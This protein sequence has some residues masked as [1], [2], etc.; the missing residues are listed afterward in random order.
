[1][2]YL[3][4]LINF[5]KENDNWKELLKKTPYNLKTVK[6][7]SWHPNWFMFVYNLF[8]SDLSNYVVRA[9]RGTVLEINGK[10]VKVISYPYSKFDN[11][12]SITCKDIEDSI[13]WSNASFCLKVDGILI[14]TAKIDNK[15][16]FFTNGSFDLNAPFEDSLVFDEVET[17]NTSMYGELLEYAITKEA[18]DVEV[19]FNKETGEFYCTG[20]WV[21]NIP[22]GSTLMLE[23]T[24]PRNKILCEYKETKLWWHGFRN[25]DFVEIDP[26]TISKLI[27]YEIPE[28]I[29]AKDLNN[30]KE[31]LA[32][33][34]GNEKEGVVVTDYSNQEVPRCKIKCEDYLKLK[35]ARDNAANT[36]V[37]F[38]AIID[39]EYDD[40]VANVPAILPKVE[41]MKKEIERAMYLFDTLVPLV[42]KV[43]LEKECTGFLGTPECKKIWVD[44][45][46]EN[47]DKKLFSIYMMVFDSTA[48]NKFENKLKLMSIKKKGYEE[49]KKLLSVMEEE[50]KRVY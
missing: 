11:Y 41:E 32:T 5:I 49:F 1:M 21:N 30:L 40:L 26:R 19:H 39:N 43:L 29:E 2:K 13:N 10:D 25:F 36:R 48:Y 7:C 14:K 20:G 50:N 37:I 23:L 42:P 6:E 12:G 18:K 17:R 24:S 31:I 45:C 15:L 34:K 44:W 28:I 22:E 35:F 8:D 16:Y 33:F 47:V 3:N 27:P 38:K 46:K 4:S 9:C